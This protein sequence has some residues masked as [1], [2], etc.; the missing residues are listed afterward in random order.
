VK[1]GTVVAIYFV[2]WWTVLFAVLPWGMRS[3]EEDGEVTPGTEASAPTHP[4][5]L[6]KA[7]W[8]TI[9]SAIVVGVVWLAAAALGLTFEGI[10]NLFGTTRQ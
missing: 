3:Q 2:V 7:L 6:R 9:V 5:L 1:I 4:R 8:T 10:V